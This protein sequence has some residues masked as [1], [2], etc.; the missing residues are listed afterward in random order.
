MR[1]IIGIV[2]R[3]GIRPDRNRP[4]YYVNKSYINAIE[5]AGGLPVVFPIYQHFE[6]IEPLF[7]TLDGVLLAGGIDIDPSSYDEAPLT[8][9][10]PTD[11][12]LDRLEMLLVRWAYDHNVPLLGICRGLQ[13]INVALGGTLYQDIDTQCPGSLE[14]SSW[15]AP[16]EQIIHTISIDPQSMMARIFERTE[17]PANSLHHQAI[18][19]IG[20]DIVVSGRSPDG[21]IELIEI[22]G[23]RFMLAA[24]CHPEEIYDLHRI[25]ARLFAAFIEA[26]QMKEK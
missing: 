14:H 19:E 12:Q 25:W 26:C 10:T 24:Q 15:L 2:G 17:V 21:V 8:S 9:L 16:R 23:K 7:N 20:Q 3:P 1:P 18:K 22:P 4:I 6:E 11:P 5:Q 13:L